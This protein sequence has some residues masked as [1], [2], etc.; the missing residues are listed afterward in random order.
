M[1]LVIRMWDRVKKLQTIVKIQA[2]YKLNFHE[3]EIECTGSGEWEWE[4]QEE[5]YLFNFLYFFYTY[6]TGESEKPNYF[7]FFL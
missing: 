2:I 1:L 3:L 6:Q 4:G 5:A 7:N